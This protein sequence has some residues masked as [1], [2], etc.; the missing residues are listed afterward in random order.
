MHELVAQKPEYLQTS[1]ALYRE[2]YDKATR[3]TETY[4]NRK[5]SFAPAAVSVVAAPTNHGKTLILLQTAI[6]VAQTTGKRFIY[7]S[8]ENDAEQ[9]YIR[10]ITAH[11]GGVWAADEPNPRGKVRQHIKDIRLKMWTDL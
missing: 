9:L 11:M 4:E 6:N 5:I 7:L 2:R 1:W 8:I 3:S 10:A